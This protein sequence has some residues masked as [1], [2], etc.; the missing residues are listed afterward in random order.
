MWS[1][2]YL[3]SEEGTFTYCAKY[4]CLDIQNGQID[5][6]YDRKGFDTNIFPTDG[7]AFLTI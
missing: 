4:W 7:A 5:D 2:T 6:Y 3:V 1:L